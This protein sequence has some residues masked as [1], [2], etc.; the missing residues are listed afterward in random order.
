MSKLRSKICPLPARGRASLS[1]GGRLV[2]SS[3]ARPCEPYFL[4]DYKLIFL[5]RIS[6]PIAF[7]EVPGGV[8]CDKQISLSARRC[9]PGKLRKLPR[10]A[11]LGKIASNVATFPTR[12]TLSRLPRFFETQHMRGR[13]L[14]LKRNDAPQLNKKTRA[15]APKG[16]RCGRLRR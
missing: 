5:V 3:L 13:S 15:R 11:L 16:Y 1:H 9:R 6:L 4:P 2:F 10:G 14:R 7:L 8:G 12:Q